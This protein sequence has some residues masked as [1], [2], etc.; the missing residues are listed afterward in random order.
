MIQTGHD[1]GLKLARLLMV[2]SSVS[3]LFILWAIRGTALIPDVY[4][5]TFCAAMVVGPNAFLWY[6]IRIARQRDDTRELAIAAVED[7]R[8]HLYWYLDDLASK[9]TSDR[10]AKVRLPRCRWPP[11]GSACTCSSRP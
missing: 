4:F 8:E 9:T 2:L 5:L 11:G 1:E 10:R 6:R 3:P 7:N